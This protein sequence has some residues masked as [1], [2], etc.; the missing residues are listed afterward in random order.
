M[1]NRTRRCLS[2]ILAPLNLHTQCGGP[3]DGAPGEIEPLGMLVAAA[4]SAGLDL[5]CP[6]PPRLQ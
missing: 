4:L 3:N 1:E 5:Q 2:C 6:R